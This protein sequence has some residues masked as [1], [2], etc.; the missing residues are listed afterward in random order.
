[1]ISPEREGKKLNDVIFSAGAAVHKAV[2]AYGNEPV[3]NAA[4]GVFMND[5]GK[6]GCIPT[7]EKLYRSMAME[8]FIRYA[9]PVGLPGYK[10]AVLKAVFAD[11][12]PDGY[13]DAVASAGGT[14]AVHMAIAN[15]SQQG[16][17]VLTADWRWDAYGVLCSEIDRTLCTFTL[18]DEQN[19]FNIHSFTQKVT[20]LLQT[21]E[22]LLIIL[23]TPAHNPTGYGLTLDD[24]DAVLDV[25]KAQEKKGK[26][27]SILVDIA[28]IDYSGDRN[29]VRRFMKKFAG[30]PKH[31]FIMFAFSMSKGYTLYGQRAGAIVGLSA[32]EDVIE[33]FKDAVVYSGRAA[34]S[35]VNRA[36][37]TVLTTIENDPALYTEYVTERNL[38][39]LKIHQRAEIFMDEAKQ[40]GL[41]ALP[42]E[43]GFF[44]SIPSTDSAT[45]CN[46]LHKD[47]IFAGP[48]AMGVR[49]AVCA[50]PAAKMPGVAAKIKKAMD[51]IQAP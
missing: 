41:P 37:M 21:Q 9:P 15:Y 8:D 20:A 33:E 45:V 18:F 7:V 46:L 16:D 34:W 6:I 5:E 25:C 19:H 10:D 44:I 39:F 50:V 26:K 11:Q 36:A 23:N 51:V 32:Y 28:Y 12:R 29:Q 48:L 30:L 2:A 35:N 49:F 47:L 43:A 27:I 17:K 31:I 22:S 40:C 3:V 42:Y 13:V 4:L 38:F 1:M 24:W 14:G